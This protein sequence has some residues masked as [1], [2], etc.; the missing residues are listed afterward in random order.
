MRGALRRAR[1]ARLAAGLA[2]EH[3]T[4][5]TGASV[6]LFGPADGACRALLHLHGGGWV[7]G[8]SDEA[9][10]FAP[11]L[12]REGWWVGALDYRLAPV[13]RWPAAL[14]DVLA[15]VELLTARAGRV[16]LWGH[17]A[18]GHLALMAAASAPDRVT[19]VVGLAAPTDLRLLDRH[20][21]GRL[22]E[23]FGEDLEA[24]SP[25]RACRHVRGLPPIRLV[26][27]SLDRIV[28]PQH[29]VELSRAVPGVEVDLVRGAF[30]GLRLPP[31]A[32]L[33]ARRAAR[34]WLEG[35]VGQ[36]EV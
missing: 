22:A 20:L 16:A 13:H 11:R 25:V 24:A 2:R 19:A 27:G 5:W 3:V 10:A 34:T 36:D 15:A 28:L 30:H 8:S 9:A 4:L 21:P 29:A 32:C 12:A 23:I 1:G 33:R 14:E 26:Q 6:D 31:L 7:A 17:S 35:H 18:G